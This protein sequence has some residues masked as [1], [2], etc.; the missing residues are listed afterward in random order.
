MLLVLLVLL[1]GSQ[2]FLNVLSDLGLQVLIGDEPEQEMENLLEV[3]IPLDVEEEFLRADED[4]QEEPEG[5]R[6]DGTGAAGR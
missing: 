3:K 5:R 1:W 2:L 4:D 6:E